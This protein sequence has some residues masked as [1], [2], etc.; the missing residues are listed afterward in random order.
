MN[1][2]VNKTR[3]ARNFAVF[4]KPQDYSWQVASGQI[5]HD[6]IR[7]TKN[8][9]RYK[10]QCVKS[11]RWRDG[12]K[13]AANARHRRFMHTDYNSAHIPTAQPHQ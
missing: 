9:A 1:L 5:K 11:R 3:S 2:A 7:K 13:M 4:G 12:S 6:K 8:T 10:M